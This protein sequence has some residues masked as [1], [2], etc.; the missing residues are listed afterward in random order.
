MVWGERVR[1]A[2]IAVHAQESDGDFAAALLRCVTWT[3]CF[4]SRELYSCMVAFFRW[5]AKDLGS[6]N[7]L[8]DGMEVLVRELLI[9]SP[10][11]ASL[12]KLGPGWLPLQ[13]L[14]FP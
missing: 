14:R 10:A 12:Y 5:D 4:S 1:G 9:S 11:T 8:P 6:K 13:A 3:I 7:T 2:Q